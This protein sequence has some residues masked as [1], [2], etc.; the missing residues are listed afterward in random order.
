MV[1]QLLECLVVY[2]LALFCWGVML[3]RTVVV[4]FSFYVVLRLASLMPVLAFVQLGPVLRQH[5]F[6]PGPT[7]NAD[8]HR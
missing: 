5:S 6:A 3:D 1:L 2:V 4:F 8:R 7:G